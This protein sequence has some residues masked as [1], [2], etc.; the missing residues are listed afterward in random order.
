MNPFTHAILAVDIST[1]EILHL[2]AYYDNPSPPEY[3]RLFKEL[4]TDPLFLLTECDFILTP[5][6]QEILDEYNQMLETEDHGFTVVE[7]G[8]NPN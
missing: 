6:P 1:L 2:V 3:V 7:H 5:C 4:K 8:D